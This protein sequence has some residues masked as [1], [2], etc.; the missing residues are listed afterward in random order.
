MNMNVTFRATTIDDCRTIAELFRIDR[1]E[2]LIIFGV[3]SQMNI[4][5]YH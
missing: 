4:L 2:Y 1:M 3:H 5:G